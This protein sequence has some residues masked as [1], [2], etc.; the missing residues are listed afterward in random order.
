MADR[1]TLSLRLTLCSW[2]HKT[3]LSE[4]L[5]SVIHA[6]QTTAILFTYLPYTQA[7]TTQN[8]ETEMCT[9]TAHT[10]LHTQLHANRDTYKKMYVHSDTPAEHHA[11]FCLWL[12]GDKIIFKTFKP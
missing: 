6:Q 4:G 2:V 9:H 10:H 8:T 12:I 3:Q 7:H 11:E 5:S 1:V